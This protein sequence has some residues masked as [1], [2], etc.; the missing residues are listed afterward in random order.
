M[1][2]LDAH[3]S[4]EKS[5]GDAPTQPVPKERRQVWIDGRLRPVA[6]ASVSVYDH[7][8]LYGDG[9]FEGIRA[10]DGQVLELDAHLRRLYESAKAIRLTV[11]HTPAD[12]RGAIAETIAANGFGSTDCYVRLVVTR[13]VG[14]L[15]LNPA[16]CPTPTVF[17]IADTVRLY[18]EEMY[19]TGMAVITSSWVKNHPNALPP[20]VKS[21]N[22]LNSVLAKIEANDAGVSEA[23]LLND[24]GHV[25]ECTA[26]NLF[27]VQCGRVLTPPLHDGILEGVTRNL[28]MRLC[29]RLNLRC[30]PRTLLRHDLYAADECFLTG[31]A[32][33]VIAVTKIDGRPVGNGSVGPVAHKL[34]QAF[35]D[36]VRQLATSPADAADDAAAASRSIDEVP[37]EDA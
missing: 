37:G 3:P 16:I 11:P 2:R 8:L 24:Q 28:V 13:G 14:D 12:L 5:A 23:V 29:K 35:A 27:I 20:R 34:R 32:A 17:V 7:G 33:E 25:A 26:D 36:H 6:E 15:G 10:Y 30:V 19:E 31:T 18:P 22:Y 9:V 21:L 4:S 1:T